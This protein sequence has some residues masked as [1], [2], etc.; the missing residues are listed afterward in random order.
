MAQAKSITMEAVMKNPQLLKELRDAFDAPAGSTKRKKAALILKSMNTSASNKFGH[1][2]DDGQGAAIEYPTTTAP[3]AP[4]PAPAQLSRNT[5]LIPNPVM[6][7]T[8]G[9]AVKSGITSIG[10]AIG[11]GFQWIPENI[12]KPITQTAGN[13]AVATAGALD[14]GAKKLVDIARTQPGLGSQ[15]VTMP[16]TTLATEALKKFF[17]GPILPNLVPQQFNSG[18]QIAAKA[19]VEDGF[20]ASDAAQQLRSKFPGASEATVNQQL[21]SAI[22]TLKKSKQTTAQPAAATSTVA[23][24]ATGAQPSQYQPLPSGE[25]GDYFVPGLSGGQTGAP[26]GSQS[27]SAGTKMD[28]SGA[29]P[30]APASYDTGLSFLDQSLEAGVGPVTFSQGMLSPA[31]KS[32]LAKYLGIPENSL[33]DSN[34]LFGNANDVIDK[35]KKEYKINEIQNQLLARITA[36]NTLG[37]DL[38]TYIATRDEVVN[39]INGMM[40]KAKE[41]MKGMDMADP[42]RQKDVSNYMNYLTILKGRQQKRYIDF[43]NQSIN[44]YNTQTEQLKSLYDTNWT[45]FQDELDRFKNDQTQAQAVYSRLDAM[46]Q[47][48]YTNMANRDSIELEKQSLYLDV[49]KKSAE[50]GQTTLGTY[51][52][53]YIQKDWDKYEQIL[54]NSPVSNQVQ[55]PDPADYQKKIAISDSNLAALVDFAAQSKVTEGDSARSLDPNGVLEAYGTE[56]RN[57]AQQ[58]ATASAGSTTFKQMVDVYLNRIKEFWNEAG[59]DERGSINEIVKANT[60]QLLSSLQSGIYNKLKSQLWS[61]QNASNNVLSALKD[62]SL[63]TSGLNKPRTWGEVSDDKFLSDWKNRFSGSV[64]EGVLDSVVSFVKSNPLA[65]QDKITVDSVLSGAANSQ[66]VNNP[67]WKKNK[68][69]D[70]SPDDMLFIIM[71]QFQPNKILI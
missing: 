61:D 65:G 64:N 6:S 25:T 11:K 15:F 30:A 37:E 13:L 36:G 66:Y 8:V 42:S 5:L 58:L 35:Y 56:I 9:S 41:Q 48:L 27:F 12:Y 39:G 7:P 28:F 67:E 4:Q 34:L 2:I 31:R 29:T 1:D 59:R 23:P 50:L 40:D 63:K 70:F 17:S 52:G 21:L 71:D 44:L 46:L 43:A 54:S 3:I 49:M 45:K 20:K 47:D 62:L 18:I 16:K 68:V 38:K 10:K 55:V 51:T 19:I 22:N 26:T 69:A 57:N 33:P 24:G 60:Q 32:E 53:N 14:T